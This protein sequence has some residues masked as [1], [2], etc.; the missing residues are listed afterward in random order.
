MTGSGKCLGHPGRWI[1][2][3]AGQ[4][5]LRGASTTRW[6]SARPTSTRCGCRGVVADGQRIAF[7][8]L[9]SKDGQTGTNLYVMRANAT[10]IFQ[11]AKDKG[12]HELGDRLQWTP[13]R[14]GLLLSG[15]DGAAMIDLEGTDLHPLTG[16]GGSALG[17]ACA[18]RDGA[19]L[20]AIGQQGALG[21]AL[22]NCKA[23]TAGEVAQ[24]RLPRGCRAH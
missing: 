13:D 4:Q 22:Y 3:M 9:E 5:L 14:K 18:S 21:R 6:S 16:P 1:E 12:W 20:A 2:E 15:N 17:Y 23:V 19:R 7:R 24:Y 10:D 8:A 11:V